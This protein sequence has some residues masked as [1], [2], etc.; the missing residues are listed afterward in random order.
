M[1]RLPIRDTVIATVGVVATFSVI[2]IAFLY[3]N[4]ILV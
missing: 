3:V 1:T 4:E 2:I